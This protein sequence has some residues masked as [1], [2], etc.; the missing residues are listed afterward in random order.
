MMGFIDGFA[1]E[2]WST[3]S[4]SSCIANVFTDSNCLSA[5]KS[6]QMRCPALNIKT[7][8]A[9]LYLDAICCFTLVSTIRS[10]VRNPEQSLWDNFSLPL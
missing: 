7:A 9:L 6:F 5:Q 1:A 8:A 10:P 4:S 2:L 3:D